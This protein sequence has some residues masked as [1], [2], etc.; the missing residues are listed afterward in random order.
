VFPDPNKHISF[1]PL[2][3]LLFLVLGVPGHGQAASGG[4]PEFF[5]APLAEINGYTREGA[6]YGGGLALGYGKGGAVGVQLFYG[7]DRDEVQTLEI[8]SLM[9]LYLPSL[10]K[11]SGLFVQLNAGIDLFFLDNERTSSVTG[12][13]SLGWR[14]LFGRY[15]FIEPAIR[16]GYPFFAGTGLGF[17][18]RL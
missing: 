15:W 7:R 3:I 18:F 9:R 14:F 1:F 16:A 5:I 2:C 4:S 10:S 6:A 8:T 11:S 12:G 17:G 13:I